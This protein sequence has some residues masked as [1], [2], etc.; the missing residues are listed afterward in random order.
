[1]IPYIT[2][3]LS[4][5][6]VINL[7]PIIFLIFNYYLFF[8]PPFF[9]PPPLPPP[10]LRGGASSSSSGNFGADIPPPLRSFPYAKSWAS[11]GPLWIPYQS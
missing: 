4:V 5:L 8:F 2:P 7:N 1:M 9:L 3:R 6:I 11:L 10:L